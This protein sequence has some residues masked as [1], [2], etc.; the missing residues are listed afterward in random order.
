L[1]K[2]PLEFATQAIVAC[3]YGL[4]Y[5]KEAAVQ[6]LL[7]RREAVVKQQ[8]QQQHHGVS[9]NDELGL[10]IRGLKDLYPV[11]FH[12][13]PQSSTSQD[14]SNMSKSDRKLVPA[15]PVTG[16]ELN[17]T[18]RALLLVSTTEKKKH[19]DNDDKKVNVV[20]E[21]ALKEMGMDALQAEYGPFDPDNMIRLAPHP[22]LMDKLQEE[23]QKKRDL[24]DANKK[25]I[26]KNHKKSKKRRA[27]DAIVA[28]T[29]AASTIKEQ[30][31]TSKVQ[32]TDS[33]TEQAAQVARDRA[34]SAMQKSTVLS[35]LFTTT[36]K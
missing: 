21:R 30:H 9:D 2:A 16:T 29:T 3:P 35:S 14:E 17:G 24:E 28:T 23:L 26:N 33:K 4:L 22:S 13:V 1:T 6:A 20:S 15:C 31:V 12:L 7:R 32:K 10:H 8:Q 5:H 36:P 34:S 25:T 27:D 11:H 19:H 18:M